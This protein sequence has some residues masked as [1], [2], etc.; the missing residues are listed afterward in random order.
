MVPNYT[1]VSV[2]DDAGCILSCLSDVTLNTLKPNLV[3]MLF[4]YSVLTSKKA[5]PITITK[6]DRLMMF[7]EIIAVCSKNNMKSVS[8]LCDC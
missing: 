5:Q 4:K 8:I 7:K 2:I 1:D 6:I 3:F